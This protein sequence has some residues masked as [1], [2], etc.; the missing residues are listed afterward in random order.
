MGGKRLILDHHEIDSVI[1]QLGK[2]T[3]SFWHVQGDHVYTNG[4]KYKATTFYSNGPTLHENWKEHEMMEAKKKLKLAGGNS[5]CRHFDN[6]VNNGP[7]KPLGSKRVWSIY[8]TAFQ[9]WKCMG[10][11]GIRKA[12]NLQII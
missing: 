7:D 9:A 5:T 3:G 2:I 4:K 10:S 6:W 12:I 11:D 8:I 1:T